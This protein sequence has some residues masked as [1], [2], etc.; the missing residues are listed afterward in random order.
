MKKERRKRRANAYIYE[1]FTT[2]TVAKLVRG[3][4]FLIVQHSAHAET[5]SVSQ[6]IVVAIEYRQVALHWASIFN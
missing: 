5:L 4:R 1:R 2:E 3:K 6:V